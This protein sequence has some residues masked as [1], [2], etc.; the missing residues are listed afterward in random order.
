M[1][2]T[3]PFDPKP[4]YTD[5]WTQDPCPLDLIAVWCPASDL[6]AIRLLRPP[7]Y[8]TLWTQDDSLCVRVFL[9]PNYIILAPRK[10]H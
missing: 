2:P 5:G 6:S 7:V 10:K 1:L 3:D 9:K 8:G 4:K